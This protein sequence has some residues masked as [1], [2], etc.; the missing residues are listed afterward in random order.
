MFFQIQKSADRRETWAFYWH[1]RRK[2]RHEKRISK[3]TFP[4]E[5]VTS[6]HIMYKESLDREK[7]CI[8]DDQENLAQWHL[9]VEK[10]NQTVDEAETSQ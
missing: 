6:L 5:H 9:S 2:E 8:L 4:V 3:K 1:E 10:R 7:L